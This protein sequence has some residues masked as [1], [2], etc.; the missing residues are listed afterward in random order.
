MD[1]LVDA[2]KGLPYDPNNEYSIPYFWGTV[3]L[4]MTK[5]KS[6]KLT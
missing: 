4:F 6:V 5:Q 3:E 2:V 1:E